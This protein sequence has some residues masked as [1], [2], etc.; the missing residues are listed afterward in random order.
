VQVSVPT[1]QDLTHA[2]YLPFETSPFFLSADLIIQHVHV[3]SKSIIVNTLFYGAYKIIST[4]YDTAVHY[5]PIRYERM[6]YNTIQHI[7]CIPNYI[8]SYDPTHANL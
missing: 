5:N 7:F 3:E 6:K 2:L 8:H 4:P 1:T